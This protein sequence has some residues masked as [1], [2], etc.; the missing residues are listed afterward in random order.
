MTCE[1][2][3]AGMDL[4]C[5]TV[6]RKYYQQVVLVNREDVLNKVITTSYVNIDDE[7]LCRNRVYFNLKP[8]KAGFRFVV[9]ENSSSIFGTA[10]KTMVN[11]IPQYSHTV[12]IIVLG[13]DEPT[14][15]ILKQL[16]YAD[17]FA[18]LQYQDGIIE[19]FGFE[20]G[21]TTSNYTYDPQNLEGG[22][23][24]KLNSLSDS[25]EDE[26]PFVYKSQTP[27]NEATEFDANFEDTSLEL[28]GD[29]NDD[30]NNDFNNQ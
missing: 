5:A 18:A 13:V 27:G 14:K 12:N 6:A 8:G 11:G 16:D 7:Y 9:N 17:Y 15:C 22:A 20:Y 21:L 29:F 23:I 28:A 3:R 24:I 1:K 30:F 19:V 4:S 25:L 10:E 2:L 26:L